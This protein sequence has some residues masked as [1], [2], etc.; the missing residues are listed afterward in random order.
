MATLEAAIAF[1]KQQAEEAAS[2]DDSVDGASGPAAH[3]EDD[4]DDDERRDEHR[5][6]ATS[7]ALHSKLCFD[8]GELL[9]GCSSIAAHSWGTGSALLGTAGHE[10]SS[11]IIW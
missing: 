11:Y 8:H 10:M 1:L 4:D 9:R 2:G 6:P 3:D 7:S 5:R